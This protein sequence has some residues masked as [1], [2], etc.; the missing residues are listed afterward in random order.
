[1]ARLTLVLVARMPA[2]GVADF[3][4][5]ERQVLPLLS[6][7][8]GRLERR[9]RTADATAEVHIVSFATRKGLEAFRADPGRAAA[10]PL[11]SR[12]QAVTQLLEVQDVGPEE[13]AEPS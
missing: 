5:Y 7:H 10:A 11:L 3:Q 1:M 4:A 8:G 13:E 2:G 6:R 12:S 9:L